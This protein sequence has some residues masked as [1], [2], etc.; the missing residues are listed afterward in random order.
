MGKY[1]SEQDTG[2]AVLQELCSGEDSWQNRQSKIPSE[3]DENC[4]N[5]KIGQWH[6][7]LMGN[8]LL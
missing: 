1:Q 2:L 7:E 8:G 6:R 3:I 4:E 5:N